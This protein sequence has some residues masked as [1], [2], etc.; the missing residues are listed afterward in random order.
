MGEVLVV[1][2]ARCGCWFGQGAAVRRDPCGLLL[3][4]I[5]DLSLN[6][7]QLDILSSSALAFSSMQPHSAGNFSK[8]L[9]VQPHLSMALLMGLFFPAKMS[10]KCGGRHSSSASDSSCSLLPLGTSSTTVRCSAS[11]S[12]TSVVSCGGL[13][14]ADALVA[15]ILEAS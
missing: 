3:L 2:L 14:A 10:T 6:G 1:P 12:V 9:V 15:E 13:G 11:V 5:E 8:D 4:L 7:L